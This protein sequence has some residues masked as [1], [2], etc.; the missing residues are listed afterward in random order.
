MGMISRIKFTSIG[1]PVKKQRN[2]LCT[3]KAINNHKDL[4]Y[5]YVDNG[6]HYFDCPKC[7]YKNKI[8]IMHT[9]ELVRYN[10]IKKPCMVCKN[11]KFKYTINKPL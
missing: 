5:A 10:Q 6:K 11:Y 8:S 9:D 4:L 7:G 3:I 2:L 1:K